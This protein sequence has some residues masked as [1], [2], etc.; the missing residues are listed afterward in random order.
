MD[1]SLGSSS[2]AVA[3]SALGHEETERMRQDAGGT[4][5]HMPGKTLPTRALNVEDGGQ[6]AEYGFDAMANAAERLLH[7]VWPLDLLIVFARS[8]SWIRR[9]RQRRSSSAASLKS[10]S[11]IKTRSR[12]ARTNFAKTLGSR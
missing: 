5:H 2:T 9:L 10:L 3:V 6:R 7:P 8:S 11:P 1:P 12:R 4:A